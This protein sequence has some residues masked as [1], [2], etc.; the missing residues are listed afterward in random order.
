MSMPRW[1]RPSRRWGPPDDHPGPGIWTLRP[2]TNRTERQYLCVNYPTIEVGIK[3]GAMG[4]QPWRWSGGQ[5][6]RQPWRWSSEEKNR[7]R[8]GKTLVG[9]TYIPVRSFAPKGVLHKK[10]L[11]FVG[12]T[13]QRPRPTILQGGDGEAEGA[14]ANSKS[15]R[16]TQQSCRACHPSR[17]TPNWIGPALLN[18]SNA[19]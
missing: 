4:K 1:F 15:G 3:Y 9:L 12:R 10:P 6:G 19:E 7:F 13:G 18:A 11:C 17:L 14:T 16:F 5:R 8:T 2:W